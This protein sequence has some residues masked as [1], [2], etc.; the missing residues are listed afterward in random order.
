MS[1][2]GGAA[3]EGLRLASSGWK[4]GILLNIL[5]CPEQSPTAENSSTRNNRAKV[6]KPWFKCLQVINQATKSQMG[7]ILLP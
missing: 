4:S 3:G 6:E 5:P 2:L 7:S 1:K